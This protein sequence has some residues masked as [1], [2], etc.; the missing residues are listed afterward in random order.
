MK[1]RIK[2]GALVGQD[3]GYGRWPATKAG[4]DVDPGMVFDIEPMGQYFGCRADG[5]GRKTWQGECGGY[6]N[7]CITVFSKDDIEF[8][9]SPS[10][11]RSE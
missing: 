8:L 11:E 2:V 10:T 6:G 4:E 7:G 9:P 5:F 1:G 3:H